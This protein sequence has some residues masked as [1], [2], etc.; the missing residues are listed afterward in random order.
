MLSGASASPSNSCLAPIRIKSIA[1]LPFPERIVGAEVPVV[2]AEVVFTTGGCLVLHTP[3]L[4]LHTPVLVLQTLLS[5]SRSTHEAR[6]INPCS[7][8]AFRDAGVVNLDFS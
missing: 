8:V 1:G 6:Q 3:V 5:C 4:V 2:S 7:M